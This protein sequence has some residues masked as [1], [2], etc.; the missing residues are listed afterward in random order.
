MASDESAASPEGDEEIMETEPDTQSF[1]FKTFE[2]MRRSFF[3]DDGAKQKQYV[4]T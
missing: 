1:Q 2:E 4:A 3:E